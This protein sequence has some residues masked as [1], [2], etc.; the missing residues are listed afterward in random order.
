MGINAIA[1]HKCDSMGHIIPHTGKGKLRKK[2]TA[3]ADF[4]FAFLHFPLPQLQ[5][6][7]KCYS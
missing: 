5:N 1:L 3:S 7:T 2:N 4:P 6:R